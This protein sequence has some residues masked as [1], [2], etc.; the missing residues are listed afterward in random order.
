[1]G[2]LLTY[3]L[4]NMDNTEKRF[5]TVAKVMK[6][7]KSFNK[8]VTVFAVLTTTNFIVKNVRQNEQDTKIRKLEKEIE[9]L[10][11]EKGE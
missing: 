5:H 7:Q 11:A 10:K 1:M 4:R 3:I 2:E 6:K 9:A 8:S